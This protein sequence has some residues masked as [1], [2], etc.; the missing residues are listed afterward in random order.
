M[1]DLW[2]IGCTKGM[3]SADEAER[4]WIGVGDCRETDTP[5]H[6]YIYMN[7]W[8]D[9]GG[10]YRSRMFDDSPKDYLRVNS[11]RAFIAYAVRHLSPQAAGIQP[12]NA[13]LQIRA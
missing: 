11:G 4:L 3:N 7:R 8:N 6:P 1:R 12:I 10:Q 13:N 9:W 2:D 5:S